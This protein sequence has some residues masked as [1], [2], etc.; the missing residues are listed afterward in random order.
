MSKFTGFVGMSPLKA[1][2]L[3]LTTCSIVGLSIGST[4]TGSGDGPPLDPCDPSGTPW[5]YPVDAAGI[6]QPDRWERFAWDGFIAM[7]WPHLVG[8]SPGQPDPDKSLC[9]P[10]DSLPTWATWM[11]KAQLLLPDGASPGTWEKPTYSKPMYTPPSGGPTLPLL[12]TLSMNSDPDLLGEFDE[13]FS[14]RPLIDQNGNF[15]IYQIYLNQSEFEYFRQ[16]GYYDA[17]N[18]HKAFMQDPPAFVGFPESGSP[19][20]FSPPIKLPDYARQGA[21]EIKVSYK[22]L[23]DSEVDSGRFFMREVYY[24]SNDPDATAPCGPVTLGLVGMHVLQLTPT[25]G[26]TWFWATFEHVDNVKVHPT[27]PTGVPSFNP[28]P[29]SADCPPPY[30]TGYSCN[31]DKCTPFDSPACPPAEISAENPLNVCNAY[32]DQVVNVS[33]V[34]EMDIPA[35]IEAVNIEYQAALPAPWRYYELIRTV[36]PDPDGTCC[37]LPDPENTVNTCFMSNT[38]M[39]TYTQYYNEFDFLPRCNDDTIPTLGINCTDC[40]AIGVPQGAPVDSDGI[41]TSTS[42]QVFTFMLLSADDSCDADINIDNF[43]DEK[44]V[45]EIILAWGLVPDGSRPRADLDID[46]DVDGED[47][48]LLL[49]RWGECETTLPLQPAHREPGLDK[50]I[51]ELKPRR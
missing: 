23:T 12:G 8:G 1:C 7:N 4:A 18:Q 17:R 5:I 40:H 22:Q 30:L 19:D 20:E 32:L 33:R 48:A 44:D 51:N 2:V 26:K 31:G 3:L 13:A 29:D 50:L 36:Q 10:G 27:N 34:E 9:E 42:Y 24:A 14:D 6:D 37:I 25:T 38:T 15:V 49:A 45:A 41:P 47:L 43:I 46:G 21:I 39:E 11:L 16:T 28:G 35:S